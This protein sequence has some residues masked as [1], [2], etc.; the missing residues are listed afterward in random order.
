MDAISLLSMLNTMSIPEKVLKAGKEKVL[1]HYMKGMA[2]SAAKTKRMIEKCDSDIEAY[3][4]KKEKMKVS[5]QEVFDTRVM[6]YYTPHIDALY[7]EVTPKRR[8]I[9]IKKPAT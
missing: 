1:A 2:A 3:K 5:L 9:K 6:T 4:E 8:V 7:E